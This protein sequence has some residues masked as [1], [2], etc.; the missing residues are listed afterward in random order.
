M[1]NYDHLC[2]WCGAEENAWFCRQCFVHAL[3]Q[4]SPTD[5]AETPDTIPE[6]L[7]PEPNILEYLLAIVEES[8]A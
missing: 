6:Q 3:E 4:Q 8:P 7:L 5:Q 2:F 1:I